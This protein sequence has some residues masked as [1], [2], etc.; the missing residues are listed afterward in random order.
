M[1]PSHAHH[2]LT[3]AFAQTCPSLL[4]PL[5]LEFKVGCTPPCFKGE[6]TCFRKGECPR[7]E[8]GALREIVGKTIK[9]HSELGIPLASTWEDSVSM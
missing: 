3:R 4:P 8:C 1:T 6:R 2:K 7:S 9:T 5:K